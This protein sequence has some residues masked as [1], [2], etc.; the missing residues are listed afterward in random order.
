ML[1][2]ALLTPECAA[3]WNKMMSYMNLC[4][5]SLAR[6]TPGMTLGV[7]YSAPTLSVFG[8]GRTGTQRGGV[9]LS[10]STVAFPVLLCA[11]KLSAF[12]LINVIAHLCWR[13]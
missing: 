7:T 10:H 13:C 4:M 6:I 2:L 8:S 12:V 5:C 3:N 9:D 11:C 1:S